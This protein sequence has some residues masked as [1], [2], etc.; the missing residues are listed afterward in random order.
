MQG[1]VGGWPSCSQVF[2]GVNFDASILVLMGKKKR[3]RGGTATIRSRG[4]KNYYFVFVLTMV[5][6]VPHR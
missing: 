3:S 6:L 4:K 1:L 2:K 5:Q